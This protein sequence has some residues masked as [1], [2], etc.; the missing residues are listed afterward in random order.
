MDNKILVIANISTL[1]IGGA[2][3]YLPKKYSW[4][5]VNLGILISFRVQI[6][7]AMIYDYQ[8]K[9]TAVSDNNSL[10]AQ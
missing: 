2:L 5:L 9:K 8:M 3:I 1:I 4:K 7:D 10:V 6:I